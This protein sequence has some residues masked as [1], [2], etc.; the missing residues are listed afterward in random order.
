MPDRGGRGAGGRR[1][2]S[3]VDASRADIGSATLAP[4]GRSQHQSRDGPRRHARTRWPSS[5]RLFALGS[6]FAGKV[7]DDDARLGGHAPVRARPGARARTCILAITFGSVIWMVLLAGI[8]WSRTSA[9]FVLVLVPVAGRRPGGGP[10]PGD[11]HRGARRPGRRRWARA[12]RSS[13]P[14]DRTRTHARSPSDPARVS[15]DRRC[16]PS[17]WSS[18]R[19]LPSWRKAQQRLR[20]AGP[21]PTSR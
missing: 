12:V 20:R 9:T 5:Q 21:T 13:P 4:A 10:P 8:I 2:R 16:S 7:L 14:A 19:A 15:A 1:T 11:A 18:W 3:R 17:C 6:R